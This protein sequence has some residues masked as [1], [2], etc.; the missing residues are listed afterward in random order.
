VLFRSP[1]KV[2]QEFPQLPA[3]E[4]YDDLLARFIDEL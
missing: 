2:Q 4:A 3:V 1:V